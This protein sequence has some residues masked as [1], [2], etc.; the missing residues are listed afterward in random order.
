MR[1]ELKLNCI[2]CGHSVSLDEN[3][4]ADYMGEIKCNACSAILAVKIEDG[5]LKMMQFVKFF[6]PSPED[7][8]LRR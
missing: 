4:Y 3:A 2:I 1:R 5:K 7:S 6:R 8:L